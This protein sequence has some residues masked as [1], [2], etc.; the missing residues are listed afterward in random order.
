MLCDPRAR[1]VLEFGDL[2]NTSSDWFYRS[3]LWTLYSTGESLPS[4]NA[5]VSYVPI[6]A[7]QPFVADSSA[8]LVRA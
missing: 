5:R 7:A 1:S 8:W 6:L 2:G 3:D 4:R